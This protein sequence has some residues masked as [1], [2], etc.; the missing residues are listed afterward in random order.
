MKKFYREDG[1]PDRIEW[2]D[3]TIYLREDGTLKRIE[4]DDG[5]VFLYDERGKLLWCGKKRDNGS[6]LRYPRYDYF[7]AIW[8]TLIAVLVIWMTQ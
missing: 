5:D 3:S 7:F 1:T 2:Y 8:I 4:W 6:P